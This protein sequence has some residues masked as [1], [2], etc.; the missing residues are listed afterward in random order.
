MRFQCSV[1]ELW[2]ALSTATHALSARTT[3]PILEGVL[4]EAEEGSLKITC[5]DGSMT[6][7][8]TV[9]A[10]IEEEGRAVLPGRLFS[11]VIRKLPPAELSASL[12]ERDV[13]T[14]R[15]QGSRTNIAGMSAAFFPQ[16]PK[17]EAEYFLELPQPMVKEMIRQTS[18]AVSADESRKILTGA[19][20]EIGR[21]EV[22]MVA[23]DG[24]QLA[25][26][27]A[28]IT[29]ETPEV[30]T[31]IPGKFLEELAK[32]LSDDEEARVTL[33]FGKSSQLMCSM[34]RATLYTTLLEGEFINYR[35]ILPEEWRTRLLIN[36]EQM[37]LCVDRAA[38]MAREGKN[39]FIK[40][41]IDDGVMEITSNSESGDAYEE[42]P[43]EQ[44]GDGLEIGFNVR[45]LA[46]AL[47]AI[48]EEQV[49]LN[50]QTSVRP[51]VI[52]PVTESAFVYV[53]LP[54][55]INA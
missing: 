51:M 2:G 27:I 28:L 54:V 41:K 25:V 15:C 23:L 32:V 20:M 46:D 30:R 24:F 40:L 19:L 22:R 29:D 7:T 17:L 48:S 50:F 8:S 52:K 55:R 45:Y 21:G 47:R 39:N 36:R 10:E 18:F 14:L 42:L 38:L 37:A 16:K 3:M 33:V 4:I 49:Y 43:V 31:I 35:S 34:G 44:E 6:I 53:V 12:N 26:R 13:M 11:D 5:S 9:T 1:S